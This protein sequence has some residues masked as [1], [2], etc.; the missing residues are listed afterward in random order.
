MQIFHVFW[1]NIRKYSHERWIISQQEW[2]S[3]TFI[4]NDMKSEL[5]KDC[6]MTYL[7]DV[8]LKFVY[9]KLTTTSIIKW[10]HI[11]KSMVWNPWVLTWA[12]TYSNT[13]K[14]LHSKKSATKY[15][16]YKW[17]IFH[18]WHVLLIFIWYNSVSLFSY[19]DGVKY[20][21]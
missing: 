10:C 21:S 8:Y 19:K 5:M 7:F 3:S 15:I 4:G 20:T 11:C 12:I 18:K 1:L 6:H 13:Q 14:S 17:Q 2:R 9:M 16:S